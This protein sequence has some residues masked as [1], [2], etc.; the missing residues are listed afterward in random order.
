M[1]PEAPHENSPSP[2]PVLEASAVRDDFAILTNEPD[3]AYL[4]SAAT[5]LKPK[6]VIQ[7][8]LNVYEQFPGNIGR[9]IHRLGALATEHF[10]SARSD[11]ASFIGAEEHE[12]VFVRNATEAINLVST[13]LDP[14]TRVL[15]TIAEHHSNLLA[16]RRHHHVECC[17]ITS[18]GRID[19][20]DFKRRLESFRPAFVS[21]GHVSNA[22]GG[23][24][25]A[26]E[27]TR[28]AQA[29]GARVMIDASQSIPHQ[30][31]DVTA[32]N[33][34]FACF[35][36]H[37]MLGPSGIG[38]LFAKDSEIDNLSPL[39][40]GG[41]TVGHV[42]ES[43]FDW[44]PAP[45]RLEAGTPFIEGVIGL[46]TAC[47][48]LRGLGLEKVDQHCQ[49]LVAHCMER[50][51][52]IDGI[53]IQGPTCARD[54]GAIVTWTIED[55]DVHTTARIL[56]DR[57]KI[58]VRS[59]FHCAEPIHARLGIGPTLRASFYLYNTIEEVDRLA[60]SLATIVRFR[61]IN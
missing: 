42:S 35:S 58:C 49:S 23:S 2:S 4:D 46:A 59:G 38:V 50:L 13:S 48:Y 33:C 14:K 43:G 12:I 22:L 36:G 21:F 39:G 1:N 37:K 31:F 45:A 60:E 55:C 3:L 40:I 28:L 53:T 51:Q 44:K 25:R 11:I 17:D 5:S 24:N 9:G 16:W 10:E 20:D 30:Q 15:S 52:A 54:R 6:Q 32:I 47:D 41:G 19:V 27:L 7:S 8:L 29:H 18:D 61:T 57:H 26:S 56:S 34:D